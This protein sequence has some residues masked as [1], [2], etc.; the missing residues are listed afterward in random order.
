VKGLLANGQLLLDF[1]KS[2][3]YFILS[4]EADGFLLGGTIGKD[5]PDLFIDGNELSGFFW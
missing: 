4:T 2:I 3:E 1:F 5:V